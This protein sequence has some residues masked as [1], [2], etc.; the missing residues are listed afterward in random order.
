MNTPLAFANSF[1]SFGLPP[2]LQPQPDAHGTMK[3]SIRQAL[4]HGNLDQARNLLQKA[5]NQMG[6]DGHDPELQ[7]LSKDLHER[8]TA[9][10]SADD[11]L[12]RTNDGHVMGDVT[13]DAGGSGAANDQRTP[14]FADREVQLASYNHQPIDNNISSFEAFTGATDPAKAWQPDDW[15]RT[16]NQYDAHAKTAAADKAGNTIDDVM[17]ADAGG[18]LPGLG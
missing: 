16:R 2:L 4:N 13:M 1:G 5:E 6:K 9:P 17:L 8:E 18:L 12:A 3:F 11:H 14:S 10:H 15:H 7:T